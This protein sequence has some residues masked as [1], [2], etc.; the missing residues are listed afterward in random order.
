MCVLDSDGYQNALA[1]VNDTTLLIGKIDDIQKLHTSTVRL[2]ETPWKITHHEVAQIFAVLT[3]F[4]IDEV[5]SLGDG[6]HN[7]HLLPLSLQGKYFFTIY[8]FF[9][10][11]SFWSI[12]YTLH[13]S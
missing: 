13:M 11:S 10:C 12:I 6:D 1:L 8:Y 3:E 4:E 9:G 2:N 5:K 7:R